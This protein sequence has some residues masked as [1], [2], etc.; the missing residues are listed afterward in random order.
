[1]DGGDEVHVVHLE[2]DVVDPRPDD[3][4]VIVLPRG[5]LQDILRSEA[6]SDPVQRVQHARRIPERIARRPGPDQR[7]TFVPFSFREGVREPKDLEA[8]M[9]CPGIVTNATAFGAFVDVGYSRPTQRLF[10]GST[11]RWGQ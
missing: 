2:A 6:L 10:P 1:V 9:T 7:E 8:G 5:V 4:P 3:P 11:G